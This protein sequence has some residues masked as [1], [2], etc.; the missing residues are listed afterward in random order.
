MYDLL[1]WT[2]I[3]DEWELWICNDVRE[4]LKK[5]RRMRVCE[6]KLQRIFD[7]TISKEKG[8]GVA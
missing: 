1:Q 5:L 2:L 4:S 3:S 7:L 8:P 6:Y